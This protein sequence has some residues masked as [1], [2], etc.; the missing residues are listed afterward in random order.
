MVGLLQKIKWPYLILLTFI[1]CFLS[2]LLVRLSFDPGAYSRH[3]FYDRLELATYITSLNAIY[4]FIFC[5]PVL[6]IA[7]RKS[8]EISFFTAAITSMIIQLFLSLAG[9][10]NISLTQK[11]GDVLIYEHGNPT[12]L[13]LLNILLE[14]IFILFYLASLLFLKTNPSRDA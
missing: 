10:K 14:P 2:D 6:A 5:F 13:G 3:R 8:T 4:H 11:I 12:W 9:P 7:K 1:F